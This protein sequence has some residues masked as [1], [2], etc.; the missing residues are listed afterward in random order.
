MK[1]TLAK[2]PSLPQHVIKEEKKKELNFSLLSI[3]Q[4]VLSFPYHGSTV[5]L[6]FLRMLSLSQMGSST[7]NRILL[8]VGFITTQTMNAS[9]AGQSGGK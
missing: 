8:K 7:F 1:N 9:A 5:S 2:T 4:A 6:L 3:Y